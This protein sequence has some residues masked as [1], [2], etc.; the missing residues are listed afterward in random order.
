MKKI[1]MIAPSSYPVFGAEAIVNIKLLKAMTNSNEFDVDLISKRSKW[2]DYPSDTLK[3]LGVTVKSLHIEEVDN[4]LSVNTLWLHLKSLLIFG[5]VFKGSH[6]AVK[7]L[8]KIDALI[9]K[10]NYDFVLTKNAP[11]LLLGHYVKKKFGVKWIATWNDPYPVIKYP[12]PYGNGYDAKLNLL[13]KLQL[14]IMSHADM[15]IFPNIRLRDYMRRYLDIPMSKTIIIPHVVNGNANSRLPHT[16][17]RPKLRLIHSGN[18]LPPRSPKNLIKAINQLGDDIIKNISITILG[19]NHPTNFVDAKTKGEV[20]EFHPPVTYSES[21]NALN[22]YDVAIIV[23]APCEEGIF[24]PTK[25]SD[26]MQSGIPIWAISPKKGILNDLFNDGC[27]PYFSDISDI[28]SIRN[29]LLSIY[30]DFKSNSIG[31]NNIPMEY[32]EDVIVGQ[33]QSL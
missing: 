28:D 23:E 13:D 31:K 3:D 24:L 29:T 27:I 26:F 20:F 8:P 16:E 5:S 30:N 25:V 17:I 32:T 22:K 12:L 33:Y 15:H 19:V 7:V 21:I 6:W 14:N 2:S 9:S 1:L 18:I 4:S 10:N 11:S